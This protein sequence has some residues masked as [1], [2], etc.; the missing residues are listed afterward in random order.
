[1]NKPVVFI[2]STIYDFSD[3]RSSMKYWLTEMGFNA[4]LSEHNDFIKDTAQNSYDACLDAVKQCD[5]FIL[6]IGSRRGGMYPGGNISITRKEYRTAYELAKEGKIKKIIVLVRQSVWDAKEDRK[7]LHKTLKGLKVFE[8]DKEI[9]LS[10]IEKYDSNI[11]MDAE[12]IISFLNEVTRNEESKQDKKP[13]MNWIHN[14]YSFEDVIKVLKSELGIHSDIS[15]RIAE[16]NVKSALVYNMQNISTS[17]NNKV[18]AYYLGFKEMRDKLKAFRDGHSFLNLSEKIDLSTTEVDRMS[19]F[20]L[21]F[22]NGIKD[23]DTSVFEN[24]ISSGVFLSYCSE[25]ETF[26]QD[27]F[28]KALSQMVREIRRLKQFESEFTTEMQGRMADKISGYHNYPNKSWDFKFFD[29]ALLNGIY[30]RLMNIQNLTSYMMQ[31]INT[32]DRNIVYP[33]ILNGLIETCR[34]SEEAILQIFGGQ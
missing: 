34:P 4:Q 26:I 33:E 28:C 19:D 18:V 21:F 1:M 24:L 25:Q 16:Q 15:V 32:H 2:S 17:E 29:L 30:E 6:L 23:M 20:L 10:Q 13:I 27:N 5:Y 7:S 22:R 31:Y 9:E 3:L 11:L 8:N 12:H 14:F